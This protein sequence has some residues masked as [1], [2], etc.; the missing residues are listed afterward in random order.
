MLAQAMAIIGTI[1]TTIFYV[2]IYN[3]LVALH[4]IIP[5]HDIGVGIVIIT[6]AIRLLTLPLNAKSLRSQKA[7]Q[8]LQPKLKELQVKYK[9]DKE[10][11]AKETMALYAAEKVNPFA[12]CLPLLVQLPFLIALYSVLRN[13]LQS[14]GFEVL[15]PFV[16]NPGSINPVTFG[17]VDLS[18]ASWVLALLAGA[19]QF[20]QAKMMATNRPPQPPSEGAKDEDMMAI[21]NKQMLYMMPLM[22]VF[23]AWKLPAGLALYWLV[24]NLL[25]V[26]QQ[27][28][29]FRKR[30][31]DAGAPPAPSAPAQA[32]SAPTAA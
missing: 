15:Y 1:L 9:D 25:A 20:W 2:P 18:Q 3:A 6:L 24:T 31:D 26:A 27:Y 22:T 28:W 4:G 17:L 5:G 13:V 32:P 16:A 21:M 29:M 30:K 10:A 23:I 19:S 14:K 7:L 11:L 12:S 8:D